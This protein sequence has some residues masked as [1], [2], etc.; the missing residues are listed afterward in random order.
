MW[1][2]QICVQGWVAT[3]P[4]VIR[5]T[6]QRDKVVIEK[7]FVIIFVELTKDELD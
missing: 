1:A 7:S 2:P 5:F 6:V 4:F 3:N